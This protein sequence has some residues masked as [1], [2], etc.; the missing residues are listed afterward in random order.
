MDRYGRGVTTGKGMDL[1]LQERVDPP[2]AGAL[3]VE[4]SQFV[5]LEVAYAKREEE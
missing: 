2:T 1:S 4:R 3:L 5:T